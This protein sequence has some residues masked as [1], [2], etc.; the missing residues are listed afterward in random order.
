MN[1]L[2]HIIKSTAYIIMVQAVLFLFVHDEIKKYAKIEKT[3]KNFATG[4][5]KTVLI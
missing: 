4:G 1:V 3:I 5:D 2:F